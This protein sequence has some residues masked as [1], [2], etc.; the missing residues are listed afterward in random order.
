MTNTSTTWTVTLEQD[1]EDYILPIPQ[2]LLDL[3]G[4]KEG[5]YL[6]WEDN[7]DGT[8]TLRKIDDVKTKT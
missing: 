7:N 4:W 8:W 6:V 5:D 1:G 2:D 3:Q